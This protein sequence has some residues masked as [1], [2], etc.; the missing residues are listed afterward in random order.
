MIA[1]CANVFPEVMA[2]IYNLVVAGE[3]EQARKAQ[4]SIRSFRACFKFGNPNTIVKKAVSLLGYEVGE[5]RA[6]FNGLSEEAVNQIKK[7]LDDNHKK[8][9]C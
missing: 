7:V 4:D 1:G 5:C 2:S 9:M 8:G 3:L 6:P